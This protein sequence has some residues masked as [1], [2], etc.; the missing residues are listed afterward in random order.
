MTDLIS[1]WSLKPASTAETVQNGNKK[2]LK[3]I[4]MVITKNGKIIGDDC[5]ETHTGIPKRKKKKKSRIV[6]LMFS[7][8]FFVQPRKKFYSQMKKVSSNIWID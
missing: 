2:Y 7:S 8:S 4:N 6:K 3:L 1:T 5:G